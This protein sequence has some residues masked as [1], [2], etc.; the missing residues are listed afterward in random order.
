MQLRAIAMARW[1]LPVPVPP[2]STAL[3]CWARNPPPA[4]SRTRVSLIGVLSNWKSSRSLASGSLAMESWYLIERACFSLISAV[5]SDGSP[6]VVVAGT[7]GNGSVVQRQR[8]RREDGRRRI[9]IALA[10]QEVENDIGG[11]DAVGD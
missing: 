6:E 5:P 10:G 2:T 8:G 11:V 7:I 3:R 1:V 9:G 4:R